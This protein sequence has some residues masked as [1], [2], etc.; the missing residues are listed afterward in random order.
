MSE[1]IDIVEKAQLFA[2]KSHE[3]QVR[4]Y[5]HEPYI[6]HPANVATLV[7]GTSSADTNMLAAAW[8]HDVV[9]DCDIKLDLIEKEFGKDIRYLV[10]GLTDITSLKDGNRKVR[11]EIERNRIANCCHRI[12]TIKLADL[13]DNTK[14]IV[15]FDKEFAKIYLEEKK[16]LL[17]V[18][19]EGDEFLYSLAQSIMYESF[20]ILDK[21]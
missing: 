1:F 8:L 7:D 9:E 12:K 2:F 10:E 15:L 16:L 5:T 11:K 17:D 4:K 20:K 21:F 13:I 6:N 3:F 18:L 19:K 14:T